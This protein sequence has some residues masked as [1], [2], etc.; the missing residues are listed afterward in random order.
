[1][2]THLLS[3]KS[4]LQIKFFVRKKQLST[5]KKWFNELLTNDDCAGTPPPTKKRSSKPPVANLPS[6]I[7]ANEVPS[8]NV[9]TPVKN[10]KVSKPTDPNNWLL[11]EPNDELRPF[12]ELMVVLFPLNL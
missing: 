10:C 9:P 11:A 4:N 1:M 7:P 8:P 6:N 12:L 5:K 3:L 2:G